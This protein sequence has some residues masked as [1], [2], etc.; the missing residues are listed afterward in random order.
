RPAGGLRSAPLPRAAARGDRR[1]A[2]DP[3]GHGPI[4]IALRDPRPPRRT[5]CGRGA[6][7]PGRT[8][9]MTDDRSLERAARSWI[10]A[11]PT[12]APD[13]AVEAALRRIQTLPQERDLRI[14]WR[15]PKMTTPARVAAAAVI[16]V[17]AI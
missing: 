10:Q 4:A 1:D 11:G 14:P 16:G 17:L 2:R 7:G 12:T 5:D 8:P 9:R 3:R 6:H 13:R 15:L